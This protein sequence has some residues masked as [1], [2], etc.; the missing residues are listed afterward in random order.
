MEYFNVSGIGNYTRMRFGGN[1]SP[2]PPTQN[3]TE[4]YD[5]IVI[6]DNRIGCIERIPIGP[7][8]LTVQ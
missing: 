2:D 3:Q 4:W 7:T 5:E 6:S 1:L 8:S